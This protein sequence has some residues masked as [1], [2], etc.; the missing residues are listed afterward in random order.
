MSDASV[1]KGRTDHK[2]YLD[3]EHLEIVKKVQKA[4]GGCQKSPAVRF[5][6]EKYA[7]MMG[8]QF[9]FAGPEP[10]QVVVG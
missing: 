2:I 10:Q 3:Q 8:G 9:D 5:I 6:I 1:D 4:N 7:A